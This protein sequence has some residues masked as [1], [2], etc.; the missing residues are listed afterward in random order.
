MIH[1]V[2]SQKALSS[3][4]ECIKADDLLVLMDS[5]SLSV[6]DKYQ[7]EFA[8]VNMLK[9]SEDNFEQIFINKLLDE[10]QVCKSYY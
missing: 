1:M 4:L 8:K 6:L 5:F 3:A 10:N 7:E 2:F 9:L